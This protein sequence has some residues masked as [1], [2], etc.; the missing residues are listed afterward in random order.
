MS[1]TNRT[2]TALALTLALT[3]SACAG[4]QR[5]F[6][7]GLKEVPSDLLLGAQTKPALALPTQLPPMVFT[8]TD[9]AAPTPPAADLPPPIPEPPPPPP[10]C[11][12]ADPLAAVKR[13]AALDV[14]APPAPATYTYRT[15]GSFFVNGSD[16]TLPPTATHEVKDVQVIG[17]GEFTFAVAVSQGPR[18]T[19]TTYHVVPRTSAAVPPGLYISKVDN[20]RI[21]PFQPKPE[22]LLLPFPALKG[23]TFNAAGSDGLTTLSYSGVV[24]ETERIDA[25]GEPVDGIRVKLTD[26]RAATSRPDETQPMVET[27]EA[28]YVI[29]TEYGGLSIRDFL[30][31][32][33]PAGLGARELH[34]V[35]S[36]VPKDTT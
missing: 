7:L 22:L 12:E 8:V 20:Q 28:A 33:G 35:I 32:G 16:G 4:P 11:P 10:P 30:S 27:F 14:Q 25:C 17:P 24:E 13:P 34:G 15:S 1:K 29:A 3:L 9:L 2:T 6:E 21:T 26:G 18:V 5:P 23:T 36:Q 19:T 31:G